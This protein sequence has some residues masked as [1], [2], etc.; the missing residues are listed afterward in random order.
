MNNEY[1][2]ICIEESLNELGISVT[3]EQVNQIAKDMEMAASMEGE[4]T[5]RCHIPHPLEAEVRNLKVRH[6][7]ELRRAEKTAETYK[8]TLCRF[9]K[10]DPQKT[11][12]NSMG[13]V[14]ED[15]R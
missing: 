5:G 3:N 6:E 8:L 9:A 14:V 11:H 13:E 7:N 12:I 1:W 2:R 15:L 4:A 10:A